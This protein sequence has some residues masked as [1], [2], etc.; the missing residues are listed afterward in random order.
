MSIPAG[1]FRAPLRRYTVLTLLGS[2]IW[3]FGFAG[4]GWWFGSNWEEFQHAFHYVDY[5]IIALVVAGIAYVGW[6]LL[7][8]RRGTAPEPG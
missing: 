8:R 6:K 2:A 4:V 1:L 5:A 3:C 7:R